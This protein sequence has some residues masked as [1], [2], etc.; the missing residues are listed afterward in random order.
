MEMNQEHPNTITTDWS[1]VHVELNMCVCPR[2]QCSEFLSSCWSCSICHIYAPST[3]LNGNPSCT[4]N[5]QTAIKCFR[6]VRKRTACAR[7]S[8]PWQ[9][10]LFNVFQL[11]CPT[12]WEARASKV[13]HV[14]WRNQSPTAFHVLSKR[15]FSRHPGFWTTVTWTQRANYLDVSPTFLFTLRKSCHNLLALLAL[16]P[17]DLNLLCSNLGIIFAAPGMQACRP[18]GWITNVVVK[19]SQF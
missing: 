15:Y 6:G 13:L 2:P 10:K 4:S 9:V 12:K 1:I 14:M 17:Q 7:H 11:K 18:E 5:G 16:L 3:L 19:F 8:E